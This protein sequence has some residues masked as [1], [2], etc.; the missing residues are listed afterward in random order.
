MSAPRG[1]QNAKGNRGG[2]GRPP[3]YSEKLLP[4]VQ[5]MVSDGATEFEIA[6]RLG[7]SYNTLRWWR[8]EHVEFSNA[9]KLGREAM[10]A[11]VKSSLYHRAVGY[12]YNAEK[13]VTGGGV[14]QRVPIVEHIPPDVTA[15]KAILQAYDSEDV[16]REKKEVKAENT[17]SLAT[18]VNISIKQREERARQAALIEAKPESAEIMPEDEA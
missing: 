12:N 1:N 6:K 2:T 5:G 18:L 9:M 3:V 11:R 14:V 7:V 4:I 17:F 10:V 16:W 13:I 8:A 15:A